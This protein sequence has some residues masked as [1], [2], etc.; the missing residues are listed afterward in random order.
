[1]KWKK[2]NKHDVL[3]LEEFYEKIAPWDPQINFNIYR[4]GNDNA[5]NCG[6]TDLK[7][8]G[9]CYTNTG[10]VQRYKCTECG[11]YVKDRKNLI[12]KTK[13]SFLKLPAVR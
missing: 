6:C 10:K 13:K 7:R 12:E 3:S 2:Y 9:Y 5:C 8:W 11:A 1:M 4:E